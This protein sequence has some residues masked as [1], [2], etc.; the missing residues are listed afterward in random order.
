ML[1]EVA[2]CP[3]SS[4]LPS[5]VP[6]EVALCPGSSFL[7]SWM[8]SEVALW[9]D[10]GDKVKGAQRHFSPL[11]SFHTPSHMLAGARGCV[12]EDRQGAAAARRG[13]ASEQ[14]RRRA[15]IYR[16]TPSVVTAWAQ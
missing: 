3:G 14:V 13:C 16:A 9:P 11:H 12:R 7:P 5:L 4:F 15:L 6:S 8:P 10:H 1:S 2:L